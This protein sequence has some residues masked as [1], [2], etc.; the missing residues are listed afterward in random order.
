MK[1]RYL[2]HIAYYVYWLI[3]FIVS[4]GIFLIYH[5]VKTA[6]LTAVEIAKVFLHGLYLDI[7]FSAY[8]SII[9]FFL[10][11]LQTI[12]KNFNIGK[13]ISVYTVS[14]VL[15]ITFLTV[16]DLELYTAWGFRLDSTALQYF[17]TP[18]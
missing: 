12:F 5:R 14:L 4:K 2:Q 18:A 9:P 1:Y 17:N 11:F 16:A 8:L 10:F 3:F 6:S 15:F 7:S 13:I